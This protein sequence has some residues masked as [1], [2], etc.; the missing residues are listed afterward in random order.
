M[1][2]LVKLPKYKKGLPYSLK[3]GK[4]FKLEKGEYE[5]VEIDTEEEAK[6]YF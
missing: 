5:V 6:K 1:K 2:Y 3:T 4:K